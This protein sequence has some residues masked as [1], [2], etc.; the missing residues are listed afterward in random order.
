M[1]AAIKEYLPPL[2][3]IAFG[4]SARSMFVGWSLSPLLRWLGKHGCSGRVRRSATRWGLACFDAVP[5][6]G[7]DATGVVGRQF[8]VG[9]ELEELVEDDPA[10][11][12]VGNQGGV[13]IRADLTAR[14]AALDDLPNRRLA[15]L[16]DVLAKGLQHARVGERSAD[17]LAHHR[18]QHRG[19]R[20]FAKERGQL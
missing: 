12:H 4:W 14:D 2:R 5:E 10:G 1:C 16:D 13:H 15:W 18:E 7:E 3:H 9:R 19:G 6:R 20:P 8:G 17:D 11:N